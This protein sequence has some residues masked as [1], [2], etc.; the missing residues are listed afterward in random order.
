MSTKWQLRHLNLSHLHLRHLHL[1]HLT[2]TAVPFDRA[3]GHTPTL[4]EQSRTTCLLEVG[5]LSR[6][7]LADALCTNDLNVAVSILFTA[8]ANKKYY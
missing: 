2:R 1:R 5:S 3:P 7:I 6:D 8:T 4:T